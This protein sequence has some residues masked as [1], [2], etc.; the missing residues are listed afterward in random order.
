MFIKSSKKLRIIIEIILGIILAVG[1]FF[2]VTEI[3]IGVYDGLIGYILKGVATIIL[4]FLLHWLLGLLLLARVEC[5][6]NVGKI[7]DKVPVIFANEKIKTGRYG[8][9]QSLCENLTMITKEKM[10]ENKTE[11]G[12]NR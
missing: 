8:K 6:E 3:I 10:K 9:L 4:W 2:G 5:Y 1:C 11:S 7:M 12:I